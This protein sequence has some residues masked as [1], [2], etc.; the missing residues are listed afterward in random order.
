MNVDYRELCVELFGTDDVDQLKEIA[1]SLQE[2]NPRGAGRK[3]KFT[4]EDVQKITGLIE[5][6]MTVNEVAKRFQTSRQV[7]GRYI[8]E[9]P[10]ETFTLRMTYMY[11]QYPCTVIDVDFM[12]RKVLIQNKTRDMLHRAFGVV[13]NPSWEDFERFLEERCFPA[14]RGNAKDIL[15]ELQ[16]TS[17]DPLQIVEKTGG[18]SADDDMWLKFRYYPRKGAA[19]GK[20]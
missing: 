3:K 11:R 4:P 7:I 20:N 13:E 19:D 5:D 6:G 17:Y 15:R 1:R 8:N 14:S 16:L 9:K 18:R 10:S 12:N 2:K